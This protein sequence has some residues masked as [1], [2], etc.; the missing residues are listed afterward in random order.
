[1]ANQNLSPMRSEKKKN[2]AL[3]PCPVCKSDLYLDEQFTQRVGL[4]DGT[5]EVVGWLCPYC[6][7]EYNVDNHIV[8]FMGEDGIGGEA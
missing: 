6:K 8:K 3:D 2:K 5:D 7:T 1:M 4:L